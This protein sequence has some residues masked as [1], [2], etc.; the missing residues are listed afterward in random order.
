M[1]QSSTQ[2]TQLPILGPNYSGMMI[3]SMNSKKQLKIIKFRNLAILSELSRRMNCK[4]VLITGVIISKELNKTNS[5][6]LDDFILI[7]VISLSSIEMGY[8]Q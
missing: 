2:T 3:N 7:R 6:S 8:F 1:L 5:R 4:P